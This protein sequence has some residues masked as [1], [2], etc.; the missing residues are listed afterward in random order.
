VLRNSE[1]RSCWPQ[2]LHGFLHGAHD[3]ANVW[4]P[5][6]VNHRLVF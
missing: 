6:A 3:L 5:C 1:S 2:R 4:A